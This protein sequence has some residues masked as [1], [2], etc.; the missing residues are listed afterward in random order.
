[1]PALTQSKLISSRILPQDPNYDRWVDDLNDLI[2]RAQEPS[3]VDVS[4]I[5]PIHDIAPDYIN[6]AIK[7]I[8]NQVVDGKP[9]VIHDSRA[10]LSGNAISVDSMNKTPDANQAGSPSCDLQ[11]DKSSRTIVQ[12]VIVDDHSTDPATMEWIEDLADDPELGGITIIR[13]PEGSL[14]GVASSR[15]AGLL[16]SI[17]RY[18]MFLDS[19]DTLADGH[20]LEL[21]LN[22]I[23]FKPT[24]KVALGDFQYEFKDGVR[25]DCRSMLDLVDFAM[26]DFCQ[27]PNGKP[28][29]GQDDESSGDESVVQSTS[30]QLLNDNLGFEFVDKVLTDNLLGDPLPSE[31]GVVWGR[32]YDRWFLLNETPLHGWF[33]PTLRRLSDVVWNVMVMTGLDSDAIVY[34]PEDI[35]SYKVRSGSI[36]NGVANRKRDEMEAVIDSLRNKIIP[37][38]RTKVFTSLD[39]TVEDSMNQWV[40]VFENHLMMLCDGK[41]GVDS[42]GWFFDRNLDKFP[43]VDDGLNVNVTGLKR[44]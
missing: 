41:W 31:R 42:K 26:V 17:G 7:S 25:C 1:M 37:V 18:V 11:T 30:D 13:Q 19:D 21:L 3:D 36:T 9:I 39:F 2:L 34:V 12:V 5:I 24:A 29:M 33:D 4:I 16:A 14:P 32:L 43:L 38:L 15:N 23:K 35:V 44:F 20:S 6:D 27:S 40:D 22:A 10:G 8:E 28:I